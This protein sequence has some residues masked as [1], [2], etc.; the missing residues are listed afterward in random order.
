[1]LT[2]DQLDSLTVPITELYEQYI[3]SVIEDMA[4]RISKMGMSSSSAWQMQRVTESG[5]VFENALAEIA[6]LTGQSEAVLKKTFEKAG[7]TA[8]RFD[9]SIYRTA[10][11]KPLPLN[12]SPQ[13]IQV[14]AAGLTKTNGIA[15]NLTLTTALDAQMQFVNA[16]DLAY[17]QVSTGA[18]S[19]QQAISQAVR[20]FGDSGL[21]VHYPSG[22]ADKLDVAMRRTVLT[23][24]TQTTSEL[25]LA[26]AR[27][28]GQ[29]LVQTSAHY[30]ARESHQLWQGRVFSL[31][32][33]SDKYPDFV[34]S[35]GYG[36]GAGLSG[37]NCRHSWYPFFDGIS[38]NAYSAQDREAINSKTVTYNG[39]S[40]SVYDAMQEQRK[41]ERTIRRYKR[42]EATA[43]ASGEVTGNYDDAIRARAK[44]S[45]WETQLKDLLKQ[46]GLKRDRFRENV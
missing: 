4:R 9:D 3:I 16:A 26:R 8:M 44:I 34:E 37:Y 20:G 1:M 12:M 27:E 28:M 14:L 36:T 23:G 6:K 30:G 40:M 5:A 32:G 33:T 2:A 45:Q 39:Q 13:M 10:G 22:Y 21:S 38:E 25:Q 11:L 43:N 15:R 7:V 46:T 17:L 41:I 29:D 42:R 35:T 24:V 18:M 31:S 19:Y